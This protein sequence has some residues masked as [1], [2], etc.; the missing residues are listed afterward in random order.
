MEET[1]NCMNTSLNDCPYELTGINAQYGYN[2][3]QMYNNEE[4]STCCNQN[5]S[6]IQKEMMCQIRAQEFAITDIG[7]YLNTHP[8]DK[9]AICLH[10]EYCQKLRDLT[11]K[12][13]K[14]YGPLSIDCPCNSW[15]WLE[16]P[17]PWEGS[18][19]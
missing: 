18:E 16:Q 17:W 15:R 11:E 13:Q 6:N 3:A 14:V 4:N 1:R 19:E 7:E 5:N 10:K 12:Y 9:K 2:T 8:E